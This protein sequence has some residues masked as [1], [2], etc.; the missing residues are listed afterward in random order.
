M[1]YMHAFRND[2]DNT[3]TGTGPFAGFS[4][5]AKN[6]MYQNAIEVSFILDAF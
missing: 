3:Y 5:A 2:V 4:Y 1:T 6:D